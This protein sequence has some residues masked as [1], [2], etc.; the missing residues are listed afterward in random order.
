MS[1]LTCPKN[2]MAI[3]FGRQALV[4]ASDNLAQPLS[5]PHLC[6][7][8]SLRPASTQK[9]LCILYLVPFLTSCD[10]NH[11]THSYDFTTAMN[12]GD[13][14]LKEVN[15]SRPQLVHTPSKQSVTA[16]DDYY[17]LT[18]EGSSNDEK[19]AVLRYETP[20]MH[21]R[22]ANASRDD[23]LHSEA[24]QSEATIP[25]IVRPIKH[26]D[27][28]DEPLATAISTDEGHRIKRKPVS[29]TSSEGTI[30]RRPIDEFSPPTPGIDDTPYIQ[31]AIDQL[32]RD[33]EI[34]GPRQQG[35]GRQT[36]GYPVDRIVPDQGLGYY[37]AR[38][39]RQ[40]Q[41][42][43]PRRE[44]SPPSEN[45]LLRTE[46][47]TESFRYPKLNFVPRP[48]Q[49]IPLII[50]IL[51]C[52]LMI[53]GL[54][55]CAIYPTNHRGL[56]HY[57]GVGTG[58]YFVFQY[59][60]T[61]LA[62]LIVLW[63]LVIQC[64]IHRVFPFIVLS[65]PRN[66]NNSGVL[67]DSPLFPTNYLLPNLVF[68]KHKEPLLG[69][70]SIIFWLA[71]FTVPLQSSLFQ[72]RY[73]T[74]DGIWRWTATQP[75][76]W[77][78]FVLYLLLTVALLLLLIRFA[79]G[80]T[81]LK[82]DPVSIAD[83]ISLFHRSNFL[84]DFDRLDVEV[85]RSHHPWEKHLRLGY[86]MTS[87][88]S[89]EAF[90]GVGEE[91]AAVRR[92]S[93]DKAKMVPVT[94]LSPSRYDLESQRPH[95]SATTDTLQ[96]AIHTPDVR[97]R[98]I[99]WFLRDGLVVAWIIIAIILMIAFIVVSFVNHAVQTGFLP[100][101]PAPTTTQGFSPADFL[102]SFVPSLIGLIL[103][104][105]WQ[106]IDMYFRALQPF[107]N[108]D[109]HRGC[110]ADQSLL[111]DYTSRLPIEII[112]RAALERHFKV[113]WIS[114]ISLLSITLPILAGGVFT[115]QYV[116]DQDVRMAADMPGY[117]ALVVFVV[118]YAL[119]TL[120]IWP[121]QHR[122]LPHDTST[123]GQLIS[124]VY[125]S[126]L[127]AESTFRE[128]RGKIDLQTKLI[129]TRTGEKDSPR[130]GFG[131]Y[132]GQDGKEHIGINRLDRRGSGGMLKTT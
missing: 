82:W 22:S 130:F 58:R 8:T 64:A 85:G 103:F 6:P 67:H 31:F 24:K 32:T 94:D 88:R 112:L 121:R 108:L 10:P 120:I 81:G 117:Y 66:T 70:C 100:M 96:R 34:I 18:S 19:N 109:H 29:S 127:L 68:F 105:L 95:R 86:W 21:M 60:P 90:Y 74:P 131:A 116:V 75:I 79:R 72:T 36:P 97:F 69:L 113:A 106:P 45:V 84:S 125:Q 40:Y 124:F 3:C 78:L 42:P 98:W 104:L 39:Q 46:P 52:L 12:L 129:G 122:Y 11:I 13:L 7:A 56:W 115:A 73:Y 51:C 20:P 99:P 4:S 119:S 61:L 57:D 53:A 63:L 33:E 110:S 128:P 43:I 17:S 54:L 30:V 59:L 48:L 114:F 89:T 77:T 44:D 26:K 87:Q 65:S 47:T 91:N 71:L 92:Y 50:L 14:N 111:L 123:I 28:G 25:T 1:S 41:D 16:S 107:A 35:D 76:A 101:L 93:L 126:P 37:C 2:V 27:P 132:T 55:F 83:I 38:P 62:S 5:P 15:I 23:A 80:Q 102:Y 9:Q 118:I 49:I